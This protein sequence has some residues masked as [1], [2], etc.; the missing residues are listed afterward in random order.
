MS[1]A[2]RE[3]RLHVPLKYAQLRS[4]NLPVNGSSFPPLP[5]SSSHGPSW[6]TWRE[7]PCRQA[8]S[9]TAQWPAYV[10]PSLPQT[11]ASTAEATSGD[12]SGHSC[13]A[14]H[15]PHLAPAAP[16]SWQLS[17]W[18]QLSDVRH[19]ST[20]MQRHTTAHSLTVQFIRPW[21]SWET[22][23]SLRLHINNY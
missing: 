5:D 3:V 17:P 20:M 22:S 2:N 18:L 8:A 6:W 13:S 10:R 1:S 11:G 23:H 4:E 15:G 7:T 16:S 19:F 12:R 14:E 21:K 9:L